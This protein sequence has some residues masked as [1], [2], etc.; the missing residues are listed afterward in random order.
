MSIDVNLPVLTGRMA[1]RRLVITGTDPPE[2]SSWPEPGEQ[3]RI[4]IPYHAMVDFFGKVSPGYSEELEWPAIDAEKYDET[5]PELLQVCV[6]SDG[7][8]EILFSEE[9]SVDNLSAAAL[10]DG[11]EV[12]WVLGQ[13]RY[14]VR[15]EN[16][17]A[18]GAHTLAVG[19]G[20]L[21]LVDLG[22][23][24]PFSESFQVSAGGELVFSAP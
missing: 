24:S 21:D 4:T 23:A 2:S 16:A 5:Q 12:T 9:P 14:S 13:D 3:V 7:T 15:S 8:L 10:V 22:L 6:K 1:R 18:S 19:T 11:E 20:P 17:L